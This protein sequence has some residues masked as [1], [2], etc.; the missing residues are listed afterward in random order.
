[1]SADQI[2][3][4]ILLIALVI[5]FI[6][7]ENRED[8]HDQ[9]R[10]SAVTIAAK[11]S[12]TQPLETLNF[13]SNLTLES[14]HKYERLMQHNSALVRK[15]GTITAPSQ[16]LSI[17]NASKVGQSIPPPSRVPLFTIEEQNTASVATQTEYDLLD[18]SGSDNNDQLLPLSACNHLLKLKIPRALEEC[19]EILNSTEEDGGAANLTDEEII[20]IVNAG[21]QH[22]PLHKIE[23]V[24]DDPVRG[25]KLRRQIISERAKLSAERLECLP[26]KH[27]DYKRVMNACCEN[28]LGY[29][30]IP[31]GYA[32]PLLLDGAKYFVPMATTEGALVA[33][34]NRGCKALSVRGVTSYVEDVGMTRA[35]C[36]R[37]SSVTRAAEA[38]LWINDDLNYKRIKAEFDSTSRF[39]RL[40]ECHIAMDGPQLY[41][42]FV[43]LTGDAMGMNMVSKGAE[44]AL[45]CIKREFPDMQIISLSGNFCCDKKPAAINWIKGRGKRVVA[46]CIVPAATLRGVLKTDAKTLVECNKLKNMGG[47]A[48]AGSIGG[49]F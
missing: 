12:Q 25:V 34:T 10:Q 18:G 40:K 30:P 43:A 17:A 13:S 33:S 46:E 37:F 19:V 32:G 23:S 20:N 22:C 16:L 8:L 6:F 48:M 2:V 44:M 27:F 1:M 36:V 7:F 3:I 24:I 14:H 26:Y 15:D 5:K 38:K 4:L 49:K 39:G 29:V 9:I 42:R 47:S 28:V 41:I 35:P 21:G 31:V 11:S 45:K